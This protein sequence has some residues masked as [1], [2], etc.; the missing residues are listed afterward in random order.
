MEKK[1]IFHQDS[2][3]TWAVLVSLYVWADGVADSAT[4]IEVRHCRAVPAGQGVSS[5]SLPRSAAELQPS[6]EQEFSA[7]ALITH[8]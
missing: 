4:A 7:A 5:V 6:T 1:A 8:Y 3:Q 2:G